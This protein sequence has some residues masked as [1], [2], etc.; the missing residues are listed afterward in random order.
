MPAVPVE[1]HSAARPVSKAAPT[2][3]SPNVAC[4]GLDD[5]QRYALAGLLLP[6][7]VTPGQELCLHGDPADCFWL[8]HEGEVQVCVG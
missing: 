2:S 4:R 3:I 6:V 1:R 8:L 7:D 5:S